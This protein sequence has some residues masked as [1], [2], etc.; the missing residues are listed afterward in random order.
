MCDGGG[1]GETKQQKVVLRNWRKLRMHSCNVRQKFHPINHLP[2]Y[3]AHAVVCARCT[4]DAF[5]FGFHRRRGRRHHQLLKLFGVSSLP[6]VAV[7]SMKLSFSLLFHLL[8]LSILR[9]LLYVFSLPC[10]LLSTFLSPD[11]FLVMQ[12]RSSFAITFRASCQFPFGFI[13]T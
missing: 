12:S 13:T 2:S 6:F 9:Q 5:T 8:R 10:F 7:I 1:S 3:A 4:R 11:A